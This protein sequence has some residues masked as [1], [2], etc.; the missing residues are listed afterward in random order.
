LKLKIRFFGGVFLDRF[1]AVTRTDLERRFKKLGF[2]D[3][4]TEQIILE[5]EDALLIP[6]EF[7]EVK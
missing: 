6:L 7:R 2:N 5:V 4:L 1:N 3:R